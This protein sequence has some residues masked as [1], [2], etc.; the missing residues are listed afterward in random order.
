MSVSQ[1]IDLDNL[2]TV[3]PTIDSITVKVIKAKVSF[4][5]ISDK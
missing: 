2:S 3:G 4:N 1:I 5:S